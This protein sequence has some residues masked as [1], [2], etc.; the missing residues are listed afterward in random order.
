MYKKCCDNLKIIIIIISFGYALAMM[1][2][3]KGGGGRGDLVGEGE[4]NKKIFD[5]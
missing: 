1:L 2:C 4:I 5:Q 3:T